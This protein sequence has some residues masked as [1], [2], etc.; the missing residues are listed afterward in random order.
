MS[1]KVCYIKK[2]KK[3]KRRQKTL[4]SSHK[5]QGGYIQGIASLSLSLAFSFSPPSPL[6]PKKTKSNAC[7]RCPPPLL[8]LLRKNVNQCHLTTQMQKTKRFK[9]IHNSLF[10]SLS[11][12]KRGTM[13]LFLNLQKNRRFPPQDV[14]QPSFIDEILSLF[15]LIFIRCMKNLCDLTKNQSTNP[16]R[17]TRP[18]VDSVDPWAKPSLSLSSSDTRSSS[19]STN[20]SS[21]SSSS[22]TN[23]R[24]QTTTQFLILSRLAHTSTI[25]QFN[26]MQSHRQRR[27]LTLPF[28]RILLRH[29]IR[30][31]EFRGD[32]PLGHGR[33]A[34]LHRV[35]TRH[36][37]R[38]CGIPFVQGGSVALLDGVV[39]ARAQYFRGAGGAALRTAGAGTDDRMLLLLFGR[40]LDFFALPQVD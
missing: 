6:S 29:G 34:N 17:P 40:H 39:G 11:P 28:A 18:R 23:N 37:A 3:S 2:K 4:Q 31:F 10:Q 12:K 27:R 36:D 8:L 33:A 7:R 26:R 15:S 9:Y 1:G 19:S 16:T 14:V 32:F 30:H 24:R 22:S 25:Q 20:S 38:Q 21:S 35:R 5:R 13:R